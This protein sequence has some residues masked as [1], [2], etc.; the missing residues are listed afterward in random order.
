MRYSFI[1]PRPK[2]LLS[3]EIKVLLYFF[4]FAFFLMIVTYGFLQYRSWDFQEDRVELRENSKELIVKIDKIEDE[5]TFINTQ[6]AKSKDIYTTNLLLKDSI[7]NL[8]DLIPDRITLSEARLD[9]NSLVLYGMTPT[10]EIYEF[11]LLAPLKSI[12]HRS[13]SSFYVLDNGWYR[14]V[15][16]NY[17]DE[18][19]RF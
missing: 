19:G 4:G 3:F 11:L 18:E 8:F 5:T 10:K 2:K 6:I 15:S 17:L 16:T 1:Q 7:K 14:F 9:K 12:F 13:Y